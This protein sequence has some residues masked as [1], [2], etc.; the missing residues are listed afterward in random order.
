MA[1]GRPRGA[2]RTMIN[3]RLPTELVDRL[4]MIAEAE[5]RSMTRTVELAVEEYVGRA[6]RRLKSAA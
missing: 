6:E 1:R 3:F 4:R 2:P 5:K